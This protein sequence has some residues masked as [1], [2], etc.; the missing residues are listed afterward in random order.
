LVIFFISSKIFAM[1]FLQLSGCP[2][3]DLPEV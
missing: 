2:L 3:W 1:V